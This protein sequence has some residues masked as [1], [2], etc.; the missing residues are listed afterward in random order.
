MIKKREYDHRDKLLTIRTYLKDT[1]PPSSLILL[2]TI[3]CLHKYVM[4]TMDTDHK[5]VCMTIAYNVSTLQ[6]NMEFTLGK[7]IDVFDLDDPN[8]EFF[9]HLLYMIQSNVPSNDSVSGGIAGL[10]IRVYSGG[11]SFIE[12]KR[13]IPTSDNDFPVFWSKILESDI[14]PIPGNRA[15]RKTRN[16]I[17]GS[18]ISDKIPKT[19]LNPP[20]GGR[21]SFLVGDIETLISN[22]NQKQMPYAAGIMKVTPGVP[23]H[24]KKPIIWTWFSED[25]A[26]TKKFAD[27][28][29]KV[30]IDMMNRIQSIS[31]QAGKPQIVY[32]H[33][34]ARFD[35]ILI[36]RHLAF[37]ESKFV[38]RPLIR[39]GVLYELEVFDMRNKRICT[40]RDS[41]LLL[42]NKLNKLAESLCP[43]LGCKG[44]IDHSSINESN[45][46]EKKGEVIN[47]MEQDIYLL[48]G[49]MHNAQ[50]NF[51]EAY[52]IDIVTK[53]TISSLALTIFRA[54][55]YEPDKTPIYVLNQNI[56]KFV[57]NGY[58]GGHTDV[59][60]PKLP[61]GTQFYHYDVN[62]LYPFIMKTCIM[63]IGKPEWVGN[64]K[65]QSIQEITN[66]KCG[67]VEAYVVCP[68]DMKRPFLPY[69]DSKGV[70]SFPTGQFIGVY[71][72][73]ELL[74]AEEL[75]YTIKPIK[76]VL[77][78]K[79]YGLF[80]SFVTVGKRLEA[81]K[82]EQSG[83]SYIYKII[84][85]SLYGRFGINP[86]SSVTE[87]C[88]EERYQHI[89]R[90]IKP[91]IASELK[92]NCYMINYVVN[93]DRQGAEW[94][95]PRVAA[96][97]ISAAIT[98]CARIHMYPFISSPECFYTDTDSIFTTKKLDDQYI[99]QHEAGKL[100][101]VDTIKEAIF[102]SKKAGYW[103]SEE[104][105]L[106]IIYKG[107]GQRFVTKEWMKE[108][109]DNLQN[110]TKFVYQKPINLDL[111][112]MI[113]QSRSRNYSLQTPDLTGRIRVY[114]EHGEWVD[115]DPIYMD[116][117]IDKEKYKKNNEVL[118]LLITQ[119]EEEFKQLKAGYHEEFKRLKAE[120]ELMQEQIAKHKEVLKGQIDKNNQIKE[121]KGE[122]DQKDEP[123]D[124]KDENIK[125]EPGMAEPEKEKENHH[126]PTEEKAT[127][128]K[129]TQ[130]SFKK[131]PQNKKE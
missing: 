123:R 122:S 50:E 83:L 46:K 28:S 8:S 117:S 129:K 104:R 21:S 12:G 78:D 42:P 70:M 19:R 82:K 108:Q 89:T 65:G 60:I 5:H 34:F 22:D 2:E 111:K 67:F 61:K 110:I 120:K 6:G 48:G 85:N 71:Y 81:N 119:Y 43:E 75:G 23:I 57:R 10:T 31:M 112:E 40:F 58:Y 9:S 74:Y 44:D 47:Y 54:A 105:G 94:N 17:R 35:G 103:V 55:Y 93:P 66:E 124:H 109:Y 79:G 128:P 15:E 97:H 127:K 33:N 29:H 131:K 32:F 107:E 64:M 68:T 11:K 20:K 14:E 130:R 39:N 49:V 51:W 25:Y 36:I 125:T 37:M 114:N 52:E 84:M 45:I 102:L 73:E 106:I 62:S 41:L 7:A 113:I 115:T 56:D 30:I 59:Y 69:K 126:P 13:Q 92:K 90:T 101:L 4:N 91:V 87:I 118:Y 100:K 53:M 77:F 86:E 99:S 76:G 95:P 121:G 38:L 88:D 26:Y 3:H 116:I 16:T 98:A 63:P 80:D 27:R 18:F 1:V 72:T 24:K 96:V